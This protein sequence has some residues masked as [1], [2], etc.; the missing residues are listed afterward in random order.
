MQAAVEQQIVFAREDY[1]EASWSG[2]I[3]LKHWQELGHSPDLPLTPDFALYRTLAD[4]N[5]LRIFTVRLDEL[6]LGYAVFLL[7]VDTLTKEKIQAVCNVLYLE[8][9]YRR[10]WTGYNLMKFANESME[11]NDGVSAISHCLSVRNPSLSILLER[12][13]FRKEEEVWTLRIRRDV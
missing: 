3:M 8:P 12:M 10:G 5:R 4:A 1:D 9:A 2:D 6:L 11:I 7:G 13:N